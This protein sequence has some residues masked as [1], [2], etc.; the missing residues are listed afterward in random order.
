MSAVVE[1]GRRLTAAATRLNGSLLEAYEK[2][3]RARRPRSAGGAGRDGD[4][5]RVPSGEAGAALLGAI[6]GGGRIQTGPGG[7]TGSP[8]GPTPRFGE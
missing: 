8:K 3:D 1:A 2:C 5:R 4:G 7:A 6:L